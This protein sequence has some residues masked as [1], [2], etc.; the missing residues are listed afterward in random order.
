[1]LVP[2]IGLTPQLT[3]RFVGRFGRDVETYHSD[4]SGPERYDL[5]RRVRSGQTRVIVGVRSAVFVPL[6]DLG[7]VVVDEEHDAS[8]KQDE[9][10]GY[11]ARDL[12][13]A[14][15]NRVKCPVVLGSAT[16]S[17]ESF[18]AAR[19]GR[20][21]MLTL[22]RRVRDRA[23]PSVTVVDL[24]AEIA[25]IKKEKTPREDRD[26]APRVRL[27]FS[28]VLENALRETLMAG[29]QAI[30]LLNR[31]GH[32]TH[33]YCLK[34]GQA[35]E[36]PD[37][38]VCL[39]YQRGNGRMICHYCGFT[40]AP[41]SVCAVCGNETMF[42]AGLGTEQVDHELRRLFSGRPRGPHG[43]RHDRAKRCPR[44][45]APQIS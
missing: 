40:C 33:A 36:C 30:L 32:S 42:Y 2:E 23:L 25:A 9:G 11:N 4:L 15:A 39:T 7:L 8:Y 18:Q 24:R 41:A 35:L 22:R 13:V 1:M 29:E 27:V 12:A 3:A 17:L 45:N 20:Y 19:D 5:W 14:L 28:N 44:K 6:P 26:D 16:P 43:P 34:C 10:L 21:E 37:C 31:R 38:D